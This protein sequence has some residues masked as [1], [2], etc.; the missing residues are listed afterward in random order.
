MNVIKPM[1]ASAVTGKGGWKWIAMGVLAGMTVL[2]PSRAALILE[3]DFSGTGDGTGA[4]NIVTS[5]GTGVIYTHPS[6]VK[7]LK[8]G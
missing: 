1:I 5:G 4:G 2:S 7:A 6:S 8:S 3:A